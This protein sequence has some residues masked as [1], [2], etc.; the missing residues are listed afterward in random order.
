MSKRGQRPPEEQPDEL[1]V[2]ALA[3]V[4]GVD[5]RA[6]VR[7]GQGDLFGRGM[8]YVLVWSA[9]TVVA[10]VVSPI[11]TRVLP[12]AEFGVLAAAIA[13]FQL[14]SLLAVLGLDQALEMQRV[15]D[16]D[17][18]RAR[19]LLAVGI[20]QAVLTTS[21]A[22][23]TSQLWAPPLGFP[24]GGGIVVV[25]LLW[26]APGAIVLMSLSLL[27]AED[28]LLPFT[29]VGLFSTVGGQLFGLLLLF[30]LERSALVYAWGGVIGQF[31]AMALGLVWTRPRWRGLLDTRTMRVALALGIP[32]VLASLSHLVLTV[33]DR[34]IIQRALGEEQ[35]ARYQ[36]AFTV[37]NVMALV[38]AFLNRA[39]LP[40]LKSITDQR[41][42]WEAITR[43]RDGLYW[44]LGFALL[45]VTVAAPTLL[46][47]FAP[48]SY[49]LDDLALVVFIVALAAVP[50]AAM[51]ATGRY[52]VT[53]RDSRPLAWA[54]TA[55]VV[56]KLAATFALLGPLGL[57]GAALGTVL[58]MAAQALVLRVAVRRHVPTGRSSPLSLAVLGSCLVLCAASLALPTTPA[59]IVG[60]FVA[61]AL[62]LVPFALALRAMQQ[63]RLPTGRR[64]PGRRA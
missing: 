7:G 16:D 48:G 44:L 10:T 42:R 37:G 6:Q 4:S 47:V 8:L 43:S 19:G 64:Q 36:I 30:L 12:L 56:V 53:V 18:A 41:D 59:W 22:A 14:L 34:F 35:L 24:S 62:C 28:R 38:L 27:Q 31:A 29:I 63:D 13:L 11:L 46:R 2:E 40:R 26:T 20:A 23:A 50:T 9:Q 52:F 54:A 57:S 49:G 21:L 45:G 51:G 33:G 1:P 15:E 25:T 5:T 17:D 55:A 39:W 3:A 60:R 32:L 58:G 61:A